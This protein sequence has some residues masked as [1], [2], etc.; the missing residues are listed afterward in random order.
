MKKHILKLVVASC[1]TCGVVMPS[2]GG[3][4]QAATEFRTAGYQ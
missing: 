3:K 1:I 4:P 2:K